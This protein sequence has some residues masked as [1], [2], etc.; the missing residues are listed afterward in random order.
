MNEEVEIKVIVKNPEEVEEKLKKI[1]R[2]VKEKE[3]KDD[4]FTP[5]HEDFFDIK[6][7]VE[8]L[9]VR[10]EAGKSTI[11]YMFLHFD[12]DGKLLKTDE[13]E[14][15]V[16]D[17]KMMMTIMKKLDMKHKVTVTKTRKTYEYGDFE[18]M[19]DY[20]KELGYFIEVE[21]KKAGDIIETKKRCYEILGEIGA[22][23]E[24]TPNMGYPLMILE[25]S[26]DKK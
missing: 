26:G 7:P 25:K 12:D 6:H 1:A 24:E 5:A 9:R 20:I 16:E 23:W 3:Q 19:I 17:P 10:Q 21:A 2:F 18:V 11:E 4:Y 15:K 8:Y 14:T 22:D 13:Y